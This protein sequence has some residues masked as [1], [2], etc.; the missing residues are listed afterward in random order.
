MVQA[1]QLT[2][3]A[4]AKDEYTARFGFTVG[5]YM[6]RICTLF[7]GLL[8]LAAILL[9]TGTVRDPDMVWGH[10][11]RDLPGPLNMGLVGLMI[12]CLMAAV[13]S[14]ADC[15]M[16]TS[17]SLLTHNVFR[18][19]FP[20]RQEKSYVSIGRFLGAST[21][22]GGALL[23]LTFE[24]MLQQMKIIWEFGIEFSAP[25]L[26]GMLWRRINCRA[27][28]GAIGVTLIMFFLL[29]LFIPIFAC[30]SIKLYH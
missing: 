20:G 11:T 27:A 29:P 22:I 6:K 21:I 19:L 24:S 2:A 8:A 3:N 23:A 7:W 17:S 5:R 16:I 10:A 4:A 9:Y 12:A 25:F 1:N 15:F 18:P 14:T 30:L 13:M 26:L 28:W